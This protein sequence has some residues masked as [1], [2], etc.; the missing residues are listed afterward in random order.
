MRKD[1]LRR[2][3][4]YTFDDLR[5]RL[6]ALLEFLAGEHDTLR[7]PTGDSNRSRWPLH[8][9][10]ID[11]QRQ[12][13]EFDASDSAIAADPS[14]VLSHR[15]MQMAISM[16]GY[17]KRMAAVRAIQQHKPELSVGETLYVF[18]RMIQK[19]HDPLTWHADVDKRIRAIRLGEW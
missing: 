13:A 7:V 3:G 11:L 8:P 9:L 12:I 16:Y 17:L 4:I 1:A 10:W 2:F 18:D 15:M 6:R 19:L 14:V 5:A